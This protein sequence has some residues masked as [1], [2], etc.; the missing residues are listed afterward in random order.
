MNPE[1]PPSLC[2][3]CSLPLVRMD[4]Y[5]KY[6]PHCGVKFPPDD[7]VL[8]DVH[9]PLA[10]ALVTIASLGFCCTGVL[11]SCGLNGGSVGGVTHVWI[12]FGLAAVALVGSIIYVVYAFRN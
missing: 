11:G 2:P 10:I 5:Q 4:S 9:R 8:R 7:E 1:A 3:N 12:Y 6:C